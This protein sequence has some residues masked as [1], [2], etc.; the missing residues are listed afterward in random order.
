MR[1]RRYETDK[2]CLHLAPLQASPQSVG[3][4]FGDPVTENQY[5]D[6]KK[7]LRPEKYGLLGER[8]PNRFE[9]D[10]RGICRFVF[11]VQSVRLGV[12]LVL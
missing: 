4:Q 9:V 6:R 2:R 10:W 5:R 3:K 12:R 7:D 11:H 1:N 8:L